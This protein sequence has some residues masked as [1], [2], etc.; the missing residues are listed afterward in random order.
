[1]TTIVLADDHSLIRDGLRVVLE[2]EPGWSVVGEAADGIEA[3]TLTE[4]LQPDV[5]IVDLMLP[6]LSG[7]E[8]IR[9]I[10]K[11]VPRIH[12]VAL[13]M[14]TNESYVLAA[15]K[16]GAEAYVLKVARSS[17]MVQAVREV[18]AGN[19]YLSP[20][21]SQYA[22][23]AYIEKAKGA[24][25]DRYETLTTR[26]REVLH[27]VAQGVNTTAIAERLVLSPRTV[28]THRTNFMRK[29]GLRTQTDLI[30]YALQR[31]IIPQE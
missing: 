27:L 13:S 15:L 10:A 7:L 20:P 2:A 18:L 16:N 30:R 3:V 29:L 22:L 26:E 24:P 25:L 14:H 23:E 12:I 28:E 1:M 19:R 17:K 11:R 6:S 9:E 4:R 31:G 21:L 5:L 8:V